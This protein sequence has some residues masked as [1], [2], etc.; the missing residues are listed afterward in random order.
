MPLTIGP[1]RLVVEG[2]ASTTGTGID[3]PSLPGAE[4]PEDVPETIIDSP[5]ATSPGSLP[6]PSAPASRRTM[7]VYGG[8]ALAVIVSAAIIV[9]AARKATVQPGPQPLPPAGPTTAKV[10]TR[11]ELEQHLARANELI[12]AGD[13]AGARREN[14]EASKLAA[15]DKRAAD[16][17]AVIDAM[18]EELPPPPPGTDDTPT[19]DADALPVESPKGPQLPVTLRVVRKPGESTAQ[20]AARQRNAEADLSDGLQALRDGRL[21]EAKRSLPGSDRRE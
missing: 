18:P 11:A 6:A 5:A 10:D 19:G 21:T 3:E 4:N 1:Y 13:K 9:I 2:D 14:D 7:L 15:G 20:R 16:Q 17:R 8:A 12:A